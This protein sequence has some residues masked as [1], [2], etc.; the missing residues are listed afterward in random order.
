[1]TLPGV[2]GLWNISVNM[3]LLKVPCAYSEEAM[4]LKSGPQS[5]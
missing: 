2:M 5:I 3:D 1:M 4:N